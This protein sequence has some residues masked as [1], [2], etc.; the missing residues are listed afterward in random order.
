MG[1]VGSTCTGRPAEK[2]SSVLLAGMTF[3]QLLDLTNG[4]TPV[5]K[6][7][8]IPRLGLTTGL[9]VCELVEESCFCDRRKD[10]EDEQLTKKSLQLLCSVLNGCT[11]S[12]SYALVVIQLFFSN[13][14]T[15]TL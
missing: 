14:T 9:E 10:S 12:Y 7:V 15:H 11:S 13:N 6:F 4:K 1:S 3:P 8:L 5:C 2:M